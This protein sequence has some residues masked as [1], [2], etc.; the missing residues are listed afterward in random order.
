MLNILIQKLMVPRS[1]IVFELEYLL[2]YQSFFEEIWNIHI[3]MT[4]TMIKLGWHL[5][6]VL[7]LV[8]SPW[9]D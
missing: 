9:T 8:L 1:V 5:K 4:Y 2:V 6:K 7:G 3:L